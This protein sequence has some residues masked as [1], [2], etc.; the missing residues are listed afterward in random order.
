MGGLIQ[1]IAAVME[2]S[3]GHTFGM[4]THGSYGAFWLS[5]AMFLIPSLDIKGAYLGDARAYSF[6]IGIYLITWCFVTFIFL[7]ASLKSNLITIFLFLF[8]F[9]SL[10]FLSIAN[11][12]STT[13]PAVSVGLFKTGG[14]FSVICATFAFYLA[15][16]GLISLET[17]YLEL[18]LG[19]IANHE[20]R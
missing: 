4:T 6:S 18:P 11:F 17:T 12:I 2:F 19:A 10:L 5:Y 7:V 3:L 9:L 15:S 13:S 1:I 8:L 14:A 20:D 16:S